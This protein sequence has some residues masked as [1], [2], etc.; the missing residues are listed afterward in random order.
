ML[1]VSQQVVVFRLGNEKFAADIAS[2]TEIV[3]LAPIPS[4][5]QMPSYVDG[6]LNLR[7]KVTLIVDLRK[8]LGVATAENTNDSRII[9]LSS[10]TSQTGAIVDAVTETLMIE[11]D[12]IDTD[13]GLGTSVSSDHIEGIARV[14]SGLVILLNLHAVLFGGDAADDSA[15]VTES[16]RELVQASF[17]KVEAIAAAA[18]LF[19]QRLFELEPEIKPLFKGIKM[20][21]QRT[22]LM[23]TLAVAVNGLDRL[24]EI[25][26][27][28]E[29]LGVRHVEYGVTEDHYA[30]VGEALLWAL[31]QGLGPDFTPE[32]SAA[33]ASVY[34]LL[35]SVMIGAAEEARAEA[36]VTA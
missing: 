22:K 29:S 3:R 26:S 7:G 10:G 33:W 6:V 16:E 12:S 8:R 32:V 19:Y 21:E 27:A 9:V 17:A 2:V 15:G 35:S 36:V 24:D 28:I 1:S 11:D 34:G 13:S 20:A 4:L 25:A 5:P 18:K 31:E 30:T 23:Q 14:D